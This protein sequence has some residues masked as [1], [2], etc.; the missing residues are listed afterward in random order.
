MVKVTYVSR[1]ASQIYR[2][3]PL[4][5]ELNKQHI[6]LSPY[7]KDYYCSLTFE[8]T[9]RTILQR[10]LG[11]NVRVDLAL[12]A[13]N[14]LV[15]YCVFSIDG[16]LTGEIDSIFVSPQHLGQGIGTVLMKK[17]LDWLKGKG[18]KKEQRFLGCWQ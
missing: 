5:T 13:S 4:W 18:A 16:W 10:A 1:N 7:F 6:S 3:A 2:I 8:D 14:E 11:G 9:K 17:A 12:A 15:G